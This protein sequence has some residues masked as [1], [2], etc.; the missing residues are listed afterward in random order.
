[1]LHHLG[2]YNLHYKH[3]TVSLRYIFNACPHLFL[4]LVFSVVLCNSNAAYHTNS[5]IFCKPVIN[6]DIQKTSHFH[7]TVYLLGYHIEFKERNSLLW[8]RANT[9]PIRMKDFR[10]TGLAEGLEYEFRVMA[11]NLAGVGKPS[12]PSEPVVALDPIGKFMRRTKL[13]F[14]KLKSLL[15]DHGLPFFFFKILLENLKLSI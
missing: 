8:K 15:F 11:I 9:I 1:M 3:L 2:L 6:E 14:W 13:K 5:M 12:P 7:L 10:V 4:N